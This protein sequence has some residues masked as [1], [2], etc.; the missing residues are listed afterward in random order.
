MA[1]LC[2]RKTKDGG[3]SSVWLERQIVA[4][5]VAGSIPVTHPIKWASSLDLRVGAGFFYYTISPTAR[6][7][8]GKQKSPAQTDTSAHPFARNGHQPTA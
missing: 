5:E 8:I 1:E 7:G 2:T 4:L 6:K 3:C